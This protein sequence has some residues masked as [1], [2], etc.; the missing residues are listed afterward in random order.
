[1]PVGVVVRR[2][3]G[4]TRWAKWVWRPVAVLPGAKPARWQELRRDGEAVEY[5]AGTVTLVLH[6]TD[7]EDYRA[8]LSN[9]PPTLYV[10]MRAAEEPMVGN[11]F[12]VHAVMASPYD[13]EEVAGADESLVEPVPM[14]PVL[15]AFVAGFVERHY[16]ETPFVKRQRTPAIEERVEN[17]RGDARIRQESDVYRSPTS[18]RRERES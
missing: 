7:T 15:V 12:D 6:R 18:R 1:M 14:P 5:H 8:A 10:V 16:K 17:G 11:L 4:V 2:Q 9:E 13:A 3:P